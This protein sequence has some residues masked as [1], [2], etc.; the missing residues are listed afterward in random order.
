M[1]ATY[2]ESTELSQ[3]LKHKNRN[4]VETDGTGNTK[5]DEMTTFS[6]ASDVLSRQ[7]YD[8]SASMKDSDSDRHMISPCIH[9]I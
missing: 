6:A 5:V 2:R 3:N 4:V 8:A 7:R 9:D 1:T